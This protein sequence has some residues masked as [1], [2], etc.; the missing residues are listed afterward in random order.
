MGYSAPLLNAVALHLV[1]AAR[2]QDAQTLSLLQRVPG[3]GKIL[4]LVLLYALHDSHRFPRGQDFIS[5]CRLGK[6]A[7]PSA[8]KQYGTS[9]TKSGHAYLKW[10]FSKAAVL[11]LRETPVGQTSLTRLEK[12][13]GQGK[14]LPLRAQQL[15]RA[16]YS[17]LKRQTAFDRQKFLQR[18]GSGA[19]EPVASLDT[20]GLNLPRA[21]WTA[22]LL[23]SMNAEQYRG[24]TPCALRR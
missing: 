23:A 3:S 16:V 17:I 20:H 18:E 21:L 9:G 10:A 14:A 12:Q 13:Y 8:G 1:R 22:A 15:A 7:K 24:P 19:R 6:C 4:R 2:Q 11:F 5:S